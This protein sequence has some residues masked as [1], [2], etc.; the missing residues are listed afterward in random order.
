VRQ[1]EEQ[2]NQ[3]KAIRIKL[4]VVEKIRRRRLSYFGHLI[5]M[6]PRMKLS[7]IMIHGRIQ[8]N[9][10][11]ARPWKKWTDAVEED[12]DSQGVSFTQACRLAMD[13]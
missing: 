1:M 3:V 13:I 5:R 6:M 11:R 8:G 2:R 4:D 10:P 7:Q 12:S 9:R